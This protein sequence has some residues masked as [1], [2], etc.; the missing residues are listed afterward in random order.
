MPTVS[1]AASGSGIGAA[2][3]VVNSVGYIS[4]NGNAGTAGDW[5]TESGGT[6]LY[7]S[8]DEHL[9]SNNADF[10]QSA[11]NPSSD[12]C[13]VSL[14]SPG[15]GI[16]SQ[17]FGISYCYGKRGSAQIDIEVRLLPTLLADSLDAIAVWTHTNVSATPTTVRQVLTTPQF[18][19]ITNFNDLALRFQA[20]EVPYVGPGDLFTGWA[21]WW[22][23][24]AF[25]SA[26][27][28]TNAFTLRRDSDNTT[29][30]F[31]TLGTGGIDTTDPFF[32]GS[33]YFVTKYFDQTGN[34]ND[35]TQ[36]TAANQPPFSLTTG[37]GGKPGVDNSSLTD[38]WCFNSTVVGQVQPWTVS[39]VWSTNPGFGGNQQIIFTD[40]QIQTGASVDGAADF[41]MY[42][43]STLLT[44]A[45]SSNDGAVH[46]V[47]YNS[48]AGTNNSSIVRDSTTVITGT[49][50]V[51][52]GFGG[53]SLMATSGGSVRVLGKFGECGV[54]PGLNSTQIA[55]LVS[56]QRAWWGY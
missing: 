6:N 50:S 33:N 38:S 34:G 17:P 46:S 10:I 16:V 20:N 52:I 56:N 30:T 45:A 21:A 41:Y 48:V 35:V 11:G 44:S 7:A 14:S 54:R 25:S 3:S 36:T 22:G 37:P 42:D 40:G 49:Q 19:A 23:H 26:A 53:S 1:G 12:P 9:T 18:N 5:T 8:I 31:V 39:A 47:H 4:P 2:S 32:N 29:K 28:G 27:I 15:V 55:S 43:G 13:R 51:G 24:R